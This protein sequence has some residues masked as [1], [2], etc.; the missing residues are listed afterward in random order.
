MTRTRIPPKLLEKAQP[1]IHKIAKS[2]K[3]KHKF[4]YFSSE[5]IYQEIYL[6]CLDALSRYKSENGELENYL[7]A[8]VT[9]RLKNLKRDKYF[10]MVPDDPSL[11]QKR[12]NIVN[13][14]SID[15]VQ[16]SDKTKFLA[17]SSPEMD[18]FLSLE[19]EDTKEFILN[20]L[21]PHLIEPFKDLLEGKKIKKNILQEVRDYV[22]LIL[23]EVY[24]V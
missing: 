21:P 1:I 17:S 22:S 5:D 3:Q 14:I 19:A 7:N 6:L 8:H 18:P 9:N 4:S 13:A 23:K 20:N 24:N 11:T 2:R 10:R 15:N 12:I 16:V